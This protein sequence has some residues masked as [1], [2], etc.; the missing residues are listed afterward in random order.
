[1]AAGQ[2]GDQP[3]ACRVPVPVPRAFAIAPARLSIAFQVQQ[4][5]LFF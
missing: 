4:G 5:E 3:T 2:N 1:M